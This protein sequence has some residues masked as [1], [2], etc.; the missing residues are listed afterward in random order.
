[1]HGEIFL[2]P[3][4]EG[5]WALWWAWV[6]GDAPSQ[7][8]L[9][10]PSF[11]MLW[12]D[13]QPAGIY[14]W[15]V[16]LPGTSLLPA[17]H[18]KTASPVGWHCPF[19]PSSALPVMS[20]V[21]LKLGEEVTALVNALVNVLKNKAPDLAVPSPSPLSLGFGL[22]CEN[23]GSREAHSEIISFLLPLYLA[24]ILL[25]EFSLYS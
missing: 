19:L 8:C 10:L 18:Q 6:Q 21:C 17:L 5:A 13:F 7:L 22:M 24:F 9:H 20:G 1:M 25:G 16:L 4:K 12:W 2:H 15:S 11:R 23:C 14:C 3:E